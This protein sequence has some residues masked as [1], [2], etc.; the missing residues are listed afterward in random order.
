VRVVWV[1]DLCYET[2]VNDLRESIEIYYVACEY[3]VYIHGRDICVCIHI[4]MIGREKKRLF[5]GKDRKEEK[6]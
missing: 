6:S 3:V 5:G 1:V 2:R 4:C